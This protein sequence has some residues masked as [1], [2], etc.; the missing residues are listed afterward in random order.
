[1]PLTVAEL[2]A[3]LAKLPPHAPVW[4]ECER[5]HLE[6]PDRPDVRTWAPATRTTWDGA[7]F[8]LEHGD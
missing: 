3:A 2:I 1:M 8:T 4:I 7:R 6:D 5:V